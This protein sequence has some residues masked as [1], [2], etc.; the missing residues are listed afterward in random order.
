M[1]V[2]KV[3]AK[4]N[5]AANERVFQWRYLL[6]CKSEVKRILGSR[7][8]ERHILDMTT[9]KDELQSDIIM[10]DLIWNLN[11]TGFLAVFIIFCLFVSSDTTPTIKKKL[12]KSTF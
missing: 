2:N 12:E 4:V 5:I 9:A 7:E 11:V 10:T 6:S 3:R 1:K 8:N